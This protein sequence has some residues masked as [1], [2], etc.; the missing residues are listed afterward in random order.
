[1]AA[2]G[3]SRRRMRGAI[4]DYVRIGIVHFMAYPQVAEGDQS[5]LETLQEVTS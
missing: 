1:M 5:F 2:M 4:R 3:R